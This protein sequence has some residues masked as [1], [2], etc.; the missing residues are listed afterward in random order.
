MAARPIANN[1]PRHLTN[2]SENHPT[3][4][5][6]T[7]LFPCAPITQTAFSCFQDG[8]I[9]MRDTQILIVVIFTIPI[10]IMSWI[11]WRISI[12]LGSFGLTKH[13]EQDKA[14]SIQI[15]S[16]TPI[17]FPNLRSSR[18]DI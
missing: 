2:A 18:L 17:R 1:R 3:S 10:A 9:A 8:P 5:T 16:A 13:R 6:N 11:L 14:P 4:F 7:L 15:C 12:E